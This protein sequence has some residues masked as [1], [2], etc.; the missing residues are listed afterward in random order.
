MPD[1]TA[2]PLWAVVLLFAADLGL[3]IY[4]TMKEPKPMT[5]FRKDAIERVL[6]TAGVAAAVVLAVVPVLQVELDKTGGKLTLVGL[7]S[8][9]TAVLAAVAKFRGDPDSASLS[10]PLPPPAPP[11]AD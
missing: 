2:P 10:K 7:L 8:L 9:G 1:L 3:V 6:R 4:L 5:P 11:A